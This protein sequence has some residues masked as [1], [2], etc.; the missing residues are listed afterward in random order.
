MFR[1]KHFDARAGGLRSFDENEFVF[2]G[3][4]H[5][6]SVNGCISIATLYC[7]SLRMP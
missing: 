2:V 4:D 3:K 5:G 6:T 7:A 1:K